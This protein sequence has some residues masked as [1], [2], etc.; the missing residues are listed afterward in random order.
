MAVFDNH[1]AVR[2]LM[3]TV[4][5][6]SAQPETYNVTV[7]APAG[8]NVTVTPT[9]LVFTRQNEKKSYTVELRSESVKPAGAWEFGDI[10]WENR[11]H[12]VRSTLAVL[13]LH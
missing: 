9:T 13:S 3:R 7:A 11:K 8:V 5:K 4:T 1:N 2:T 10:T 12:R 6:V